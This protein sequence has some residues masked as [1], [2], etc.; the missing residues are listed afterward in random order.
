MEYS[1]LPTQDAE[2][3]NYIYMQS[4]GALKLKK[5]GNLTWSD[6]SYSF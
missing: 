4:Y 6:D 2:T 5:N 1:Y 3:E